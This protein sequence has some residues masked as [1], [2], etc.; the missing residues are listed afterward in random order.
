MA[1]I[2]PATARHRAAS[3]ARAFSSPA[4]PVPRI[5]PLEPID[6]ID[7]LEPIDR[8]DPLEPIDR[9]DPADPAAPSDPTD[10]ADPNENT[11]PADAADSAEPTDRQ[12]STDQREWRERNERSTHRT[13]APPRR[14]TGT[15]ARS[16]DTSIYADL[17]Q[18]S[19]GS[20]AWGDSRRTVAA[21]ALPCSCGCDV[22]P[23]GPYPTSRK[24]ALE[25][26]VPW[27]WEKNGVNL[28]PTLER[29]S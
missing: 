18:N 13:V 20:G 5:D 8:I 1:A 4:W 3:S 29:P 24:K 19:G 2:S 17:P 25:G 23:C 21:D 7:P 10:A 14:S 12:D 9:I 22:V 16:P 27:V 26:S 11:D 28:F 6:R 15:T